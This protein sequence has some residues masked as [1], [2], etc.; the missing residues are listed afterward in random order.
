MAGCRPDYP[1]GVT[2]FKGNGDGTFQT[3]VFY[4]AGTKG[5]G[6]YFVAAG[7]LNRDGK[8]DLLVVDAVYGN[9]TT[10]LNTGV[11]SFSPTTPLNFQNQPVSTTSAP[12][13]VTLTNTGTTALKIASM[14]ASAQFGVTST[15]GT[16]VA[17]RGE[18][19]DQRYILADKEGRSAGYRHNHRQ[20]LVETP[21]HRTLRH[22]DL[23]SAQT[24]TRK[25]TRCPNLRDE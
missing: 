5:Q 23:E 25:A 6:G 8:P 14:K 19:H 17:A 1:P 20:R 24:L 13:T 21:S 3:G 2:V 12:L 22:R 18:V 10:L 11:V 9:I 15:C 4:P 7:D 16:S